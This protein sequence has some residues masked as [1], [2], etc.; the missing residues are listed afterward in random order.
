MSAFFCI[1]AAMNIFRPRFVIL[2]ILL[3]L[4]TTMAQADIYDSLWQK[5]EKARTGSKTEQSRQ[6]VD[7]I[8]NRALRESNTLQLTR[9]LYAYDA[10][11]VVLP[12][13]SIV[14]NA[15]RVWTAR[16]QERNAVQHALLTHM[17]GRLTDNDYLLA[18]SVADTTFLKQQRV[19]EHLPMVK[20][21]SLFEIF[22]DY[23]RQRDMPDSVFVGWQRPV[24]EDTVVRKRYNF[25]NE[26]ETRSY[27]NEV[28]SQDHTTTVVSAENTSEQSKPQSQK[29]QPNPQPQPEHPKPIASP[30]PTLSGNYSA[31]VFNVPGGMS[32][33]CL[34]ETQS[35][36][37]VRQWRLHRSDG[38]GQETDINA[39][40]NGH[41]WQRP[42]QIHNYDGIYDW[43]LR[44]VTTDTGNSNTLRAKD[45]HNGGGWSSSETNSR[46]LYL[47]IQREDKQKGL[48]SVTVRAPHRNLTLMRDITS[49]GKLVEQRQYNFS[50]FIHFDLQWREAYGDEALVT[51]A[52]ALNGRL[53][54]AELKI[55]RPK[56]R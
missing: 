10:L 41:V 18:L 5:A 16:R 27:E 32:R 7:R 51:F 36:R 52:Y 35:G 47:D 24:E 56:T 53:Y 3:S 34:V 6:C 14:R 30:T 26:D 20:G 2:F 1:F 13:D 31:Y 50:D 55:S 38:R 4:T 22:G 12:E 21:Y 19:R 45:F 11:G 8:Y 33:T 44:P 40:G 25:E 29:P 43:S 46:E 28:N 42:T 39:D 17:L 23:L 49:G 15:K 37:P 54:T 48:I 9:A